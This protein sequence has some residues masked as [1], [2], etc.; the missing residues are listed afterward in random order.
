MPVEGYVVVQEGNLPGGYATSLTHLYQPLIGMTAVMLYQTLLHEVNLQHDHQPQTH[1]TLMNYMNI[2]LDDIYR[3]R[4][5]LEGIGLLNTYKQQTDKND[6]YTYELANPF[7]P[8][9]FFRDA[10]LTQLLYHHIGDVKYT[11]LKN[12]FTEKSAIKHGNNIT[13]SFNDVF[14]T[15]QPHVQ[16]VESIEASHN[17]NVVHMDF[18]WIKQML[19]QRM[20]PD[21]YILTF[22]SR[23]L[24]SQMMVLYDLAEYEIEKALLWALTAENRLDA[25]EFKVA[26]HDLFKAKHQ[27]SVIKLTDKIVQPA[28]EQSEKPETKEEQLIQELETMSPKQLL[29]DLS[30]GNHASAQDM[31]LIS[32]VMTTQGLPSPVMNVLIHYVL[33]QS[34]MKLSKAYLEKIAGHWSRS[35]LQTAKEAMEFAKKEKASR[36]KEYPKRKPY[37]RPASNEVVPDWFKDRKKQQGAT[38]QKKGNA[39]P[40]VDEEKDKEE[41]L[42]L[43]RKHSSNNKNNHLQG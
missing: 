32:D 29:E 6:F 5:K 26:C 9:D 13:A 14:Q 42:A 10:M 8:S 11:A 1:H 18:T 22:Q 41:V 30:S 21:K 40:E 23:K 4:M 27:Q 28:Q 25:D 33:L 2:P 43:L 31:K 37:Q 12:H 34:N 15:F 38:T 3:A 7:A 16:P 17:E 24:I 35:N 19:K 39:K 20:I 36:Q